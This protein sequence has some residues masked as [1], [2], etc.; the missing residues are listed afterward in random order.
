MCR[1]KTSYLKLVAVG[2][3]LRST[4][5]KKLTYLHPDPLGNFA[6]LYNLRIL[7]IPSGRRHREKIT[8]LITSECDE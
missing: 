6:I 5:S 1:L 7:D 2:L 3:V 8:S 4:C